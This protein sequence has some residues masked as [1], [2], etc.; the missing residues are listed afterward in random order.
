MN[1]KKLNAVVEVVMQSGMTVDELE[2]LTQEISR[3]K[4]VKANSVDRIARLLALKNRIHPVCY[5]TSS[6]TRAM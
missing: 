2:L 1:T 3:L 5:M 6:T 4:K